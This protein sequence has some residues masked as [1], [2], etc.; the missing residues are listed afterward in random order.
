MDKPIKPLKPFFYDGMLYMPK[1]AERPEAKPRDPN[2]QRERRA[3]LR[4]SVLIHYCGG[5]PR[6]QCPGCRTTFVGFLQIDHV[7]GD[8]AKHL[9][10]SGKARMLGYKLYHWLIKNKYPEG[11]QILCAN[12]NSAKSQSAACPCAGTDH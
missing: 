10:A 9:T 2:A 4:L 8:G 3:A 12:C 7:K 1:P 11:F 5:V 6:C